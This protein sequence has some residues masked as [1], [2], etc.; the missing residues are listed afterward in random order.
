M[1]YGKKWNIIKIE[2]KMGLVSES[3]WTI[4]IIVVIIYFKNKKLAVVIIK[5]IKIH[6][7]LVPYLYLGTGI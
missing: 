5:L 2:I 1:N 7:P 3:V 6:V 4:K